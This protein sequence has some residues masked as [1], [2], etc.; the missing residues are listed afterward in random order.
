MRFQG[1]K[2]RMSEAPLAMS[3]K[4]WNSSRSRG[5]QT[6]PRLLMQVHEQGFRSAH[7][8]IA[9]HPELQR[10][11]TRALHHN[12]K[13]PALRQ[14]KRHRDPATE[15]GRA[16][17]RPITTIRLDRPDR[18]MDVQFLLAC[19]IVGPIKTD[20]LARL[21]ARAQPLVPIVDLTVRIARHRDRPPETL[22]LIARHH[23][24]CTMHQAPGIAGLRS[25]YSFRLSKGYAIGSSAQRRKGP[26][27]V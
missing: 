20:E 10:K 11:L 4:S 15:R 17:V 19:A 2:S 13:K 25:S 26:V 8:N 1:H 21:A 16:Y 5:T 23:A 18:K 9:R 6:A 3:S 14:E 7:A 12:A 24:P 27:P 22:P